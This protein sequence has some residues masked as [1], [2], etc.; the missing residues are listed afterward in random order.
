MKSRLVVVVTSPA[1]ATEE[2]EGLVDT[3][4]LTGSERAARR[5]AFTS[6]GVTLRL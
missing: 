4:H 5:V 2:K 1:A 6:R 3:I